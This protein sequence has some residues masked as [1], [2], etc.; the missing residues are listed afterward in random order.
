MSLRQQFLATISLA[1]LMGVTS[2]LAGGQTPAVAATPV[3]GQFPIEEHI[4]VLEPESTVCGFPVRID[5][6]GLGIFQIFFDKLGNPTGANVLEH[7][8]GTLSANGIELRFSSSDNKFYDFGSNTLAEVG[9]VFRY[10]G[11]AVGVVLM[12]RGRLIWNIDDTGEM[13]GLP[14]FEAGPH[15]EL[16][17]D[18]DGLCAALTH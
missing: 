10:S 8:T 4:A 1:C 14:T 18:L 16:H 9:L 11:P 15:P 3:T 5:L 12:D 17:G 13:V 7:S 6:T 2:A